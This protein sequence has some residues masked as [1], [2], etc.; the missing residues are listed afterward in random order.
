M[1]SVVTEIEQTVYEMYQAIKK[2]LELENTTFLSNK[3]LDPNNYTD[4]ELKA[5][6]QYI[7]R[8]VKDQGKKI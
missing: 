8:K 5:H 3:L 2:E 7:R 1:E 4:E 6:Y